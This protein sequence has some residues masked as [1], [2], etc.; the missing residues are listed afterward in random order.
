MGVIE[1]TIHEEMLIHKIFSADR[2][3]GYEWFNPN[4]ILL[5]YINE[6]AFMIDVPLYKKRTKSKNGNDYEVQL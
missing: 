6:N 4:P 1:G 5:D 3:G 2:V